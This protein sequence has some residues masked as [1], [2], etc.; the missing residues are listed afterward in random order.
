MN[1]FN[2]TEETNYDL[3]RNAFQSAIFE[4]VATKPA[5]IQEMAGF[6]IPIENIKKLLIK[7]R[8]DLEN[9]EYYKRRE[10]HVLMEKVHQLNDEVRELSAVKGENKILKENILELKK[11]LEAY[12]AL[13]LEYYHALGETE[14][15]DEDEEENNENGEEHLKA[16]LRKKTN[17]T[18]PSN[19][20]K[21]K[22]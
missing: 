13:E 18:I 10:N 12:Q 1:D 19:K 16:Y 17:P 9:E 22:P 8:K 21:K 5:T 14:L 11:Q 6:N 15:E 7:V 3:V 20:N 2:D 4:G